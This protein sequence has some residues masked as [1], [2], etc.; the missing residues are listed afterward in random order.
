[1]SERQVKRLRRAERAYVRDNIKSLAKGEP[2][3]TAAHKRAGMILDAWP[4]MDHRERGLVGAQ[5]HSGNLIQA[6]A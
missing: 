4:R 5:L 1:M 3:R 2:V 6:S